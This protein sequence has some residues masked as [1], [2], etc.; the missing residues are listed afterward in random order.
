LLPDVTTDNT[1]RSTEGGTLRLSLRP[2]G[3]DP[4]ELGGTIAGKIGLEILDALLLQATEHDLDQ[5]SV[6]VK[7]PTDLS[8][9]RGTPRHSIAP[10]DC[11]Y[12]LGLIR[13]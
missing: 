5:H 12:R 10:A 13:S 7:A 11:E 2:F 6:A 4:F 8:P 9:T 1:I 3:I